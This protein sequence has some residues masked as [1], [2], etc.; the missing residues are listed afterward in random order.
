MAT[1]ASFDATLGERFDA[2]LGDLLTV[3]IQIE[4][5]EESDLPLGDADLSSKLTLGS[6]HFHACTTGTTGFMCA[7][8]GF[9]IVM[10]RSGGALGST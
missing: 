2:Q 1:G 3:L 6:R 4:E 5:S 8:F 9:R 10:A 7:I